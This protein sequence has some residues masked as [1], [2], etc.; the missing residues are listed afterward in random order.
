M[1]SPYRCLR[2]S[3]A[4][5]AKNRKI[6][7]IN[8]WQSP[9]MHR[10]PLSLRLQPLRL[11][12]RLQP[13]RLTLPRPRPLR[14][15]PPRPRLQPPRL[16]LFRPPRLRLLPPRTRLQPPRLTLFRLLLLCRMHLPETPTA[17]HWCPR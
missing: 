17:K 13:Q 14:L 11:R 10:E 12:P 3:F 16:T 2:V 15:L 9:R 1:F 8:L 6:R 5:K 7:L 4:P